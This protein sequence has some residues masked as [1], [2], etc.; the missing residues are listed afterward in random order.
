MKKTEFIVTEELQRPQVQKATGSRPSQPSLSTTMPQNLLEATPTRLAGAALLYAFGYFSSVFVGAIIFSV[1][2]GHFEWMV[3]Y[4]T[5]LFFIFLSLG[6]YGLARSQRIDP[7]YLHKVGALFGVVGSFGIGL[8]VYSFPMEPERMPWGISWVCVWIMAFP[9]IVPNCP[10]RAGAVAFASAFAGILGP[11]FWHVVAK[12][13]LPSHDALAITW[14]PNFICAALATLEARIIYGM[15]R[16]LE[17][18]RQLGSYQLV[19][20]LGSGGMGEVWRARHRML[21]RPA[22]IKLV[23]AEFLGD[24]VQASTTLRR[25][26]REAQATAALTSPH[27]IDLYDFGTTRD[28]VFY[29]V[30]EFL[31]GVDLETLVQ[32]FGPVPSER[33]L[34]FLRHACHSLADAHH[35]GL[36]HRD[37]KPA[38]LYACRMGLQHDFLKVLD[39]GLVK[40][41]R[42]GGEMDTRLTADSVMTGTPAYMAPEMVLGHDVDGRADLYSLGCVAYWL[43]TGKLVFES[44]TPMEMLVHHAKSAPTPPSQRTEMSIPAAV[45]ALVLSCLEKEPSKRPADATALLQR[46]DAIPLQRAWTADRARQWWES[47][48]PASGGPASSQPS[49]VPTG[50]LAGA[51]DS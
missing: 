15:G 1:V 17:R 49:P 42:P 9:M 11:Y 29:Y 47:Y 37:I 20:R 18:A 23:R 51:S 40:P 21:A 5:A 26:E 30:M 44:K 16:D 35:H 10:S 3:G 25:F 48:L 6:I 45:D 46:I 12:Y 2:R 28:G 32:R 43:L 7:R 36:V 8:G 13:P 4:N 34:H 50:T 22:A 31:D 27:S 41:N 19:E 39:F 38:N 24:P 14:Y 33:T